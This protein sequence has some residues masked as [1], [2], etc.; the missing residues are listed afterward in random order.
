M[1]GINPPPMLLLDEDVRPLLAEVLR[2]RGYDAVHVLEIDRGGYSDNDQ[3][4][5]DTVEREALRLSTA[6]RA[7]LA[8]KL[9]LS[10]DELSEEE[11]GRLWLAE[12]AR[13]ADELDRGE[14]QPVAAEDVMR[15]ARAL[16]R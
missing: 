5:F 12:A 9:P 7:K 6:E 13:R 15:K 4:D 8:Q 14:V 10:L 11:T 3:L 2:Q 16:L 1:S